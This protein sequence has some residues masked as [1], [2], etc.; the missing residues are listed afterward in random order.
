MKVITT[1][2]TFLLGLFLVLFNQTSILA[3]WKKQTLPSVQLDI[4]YPRVA[5]KDV[6]WAF[7]ILYVPDSARAD[8]P[9]EF[10]RTVDGG[11]TYTKGILGV[12]Y[13]DYLIDIRP[14][15]D[16]NTAFL[17]AAHYT[18]PN[19][20][21]L[22]KTTDG[23]RTWQ[24]L[25]YK[26]HT[27]PE[28]LYF[29]DANNG[30]YMGATDDKGLVIQHSTNGGQT[31]TRIPNNTLPATLPTERGNGDGVI[32]GDNIYIP[33]YDE[34]FAENRAWI[35]KDRGKTWTT[36]PKWYN[37]NGFPS[38]AKA[39]SNTK[40]GIILPFINDPTDHTIHTEDGGVTWL[41]GGKIPGIQTFPIA[42]IPGTQTFMAL[43][44]DKQR[45]KLFSAL[46]NDLGKTWNTFRDV[47]PLTIDDIYGPDFAFN[48]A[49][50]E[51][52]D[53]HSAWSRF[54]RTDFYR[55][56]SETPIVP[57]QPD[58][59]LQ[60]KADNNGLP[61]YGYVKYTLTITNRGISPA[62]GV[63]VNWLPP[64][65]RTPNGAGPYA[66][67]GS[68]SDKG[69]YDSWNGIW[70]LDKLDAGA[71]ATANIHL[72]VLD[73]SRSV[74]QTAQV[75]ACNERDIDSSPNNMSGAAKEDDEIGYV[76]QSN[77]PDLF[78]PHFEKEVSEVTII[79]NPV[80]DKLGIILKPAKDF[81]WT[82]QVINGL[83]QNVFSQ[84]GQYAQRLELDVKNLQ[85][86][87]YFV[88]YLSNG[89]RKVE[90]VL[91]QH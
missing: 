24:L 56:D 17:M 88:E 6:M 68:Y 37:Y 31:W 29:F 47:A 39:F 3:Q 91:V 42:N 23:G 8:L 78:K 58:L 59:D 41:Q 11:K 70:S 67:V 83:G 90:K 32:N 33:T 40:Q 34:T 44:G 73:N 53:N 43:F 51:I 4:G 49:N 64:Y 57:E 54:S 12:N 65:K 48:F 25:P 85:N 38:L 35:S 79:P 13:D 19:L 22:R 76:A 77:I 81:E 66:F 75:T 30:I 61:L 60:L 27:T 82:I 2:P 36:S 71:T 21:E 16:G 72:F 80:K 14:L 15:K 62:T 1:R 28:L 50:L 74:T 18:D 5:S 89:E 10:I 20:H 84:K 86:G 9:T 7:S 87:L 55:Y 45:N 52:M 69:S 26:P 63:K 46:T